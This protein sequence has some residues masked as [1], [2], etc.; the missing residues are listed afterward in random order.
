[1]LEQALQGHAPPR[2]RATFLRALAEIPGLRLTGARLHRNGWQQYAIRAASDHLSDQ[3]QQALHRI[4][5]RDR[6]LNH[7]T[8]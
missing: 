2:L 1:M 5:P 6:G 8:A 7:I 3:Q 4:G